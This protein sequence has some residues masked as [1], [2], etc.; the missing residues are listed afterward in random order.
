VV[1]VGGATLG[2]SGKTPLVV[3]IARR[4]A[5]AGVPSAVV[6]SSYLTRV[7]VSRPVTPDDLPECVGDEAV[8]MRSAL[9]PLGVPVIVGPRRQPAVDVAAGL[10]RCIIVDGLLQARPERLALSLLALDAA[11]PWGAGRCP[12]AGDLR[13]APAVLL[14]ACDCVLLGLDETS[15]PVS[16]GLFEGCPAMVWRRRLDRARPWHGRSVELS[17]LAG[18]R[19]GLLTT[20]ARPERLVRQLVWSGIR[21]AQHRRYADHSRPNARGAGTRSAGIDLWLTTAKCAAK[22]GPLF[23]GVPVWVLQEQVGVPDALVQLILGRL[24]FQSRPSSPPR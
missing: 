9:Q 2:G 6:G 10:A 11:R 5:T 8:M 7:G 16:E 18:R 14:A 13:A 23:D 15:R 19:A 3:E 24:G 21:I 22:V 12:P 20:V 4:L 17:E 1:G